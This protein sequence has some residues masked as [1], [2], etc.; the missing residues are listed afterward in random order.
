VWAAVE[1]LAAKLSESR[2]SPGS[3]EPRLWLLMH[4]MSYDQACAE[5][6]P[7]VW[8]AAK[9]FDPEKGTFQTY[10]FPF[11]LGAIHEHV[12]AAGPLAK[13][14]DRDP[15]A[16]DP[17]ERDLFRYRFLLRLHAL[18]PGDTV[19]TRPQADRVILF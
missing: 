4:G 2:D 15:E 19:R 16:S 8:R 11:I 9:R 10:A 5:A 6:F 13:R 18:Q 12:R 3:I 1:K 14:K 17:D 7:G